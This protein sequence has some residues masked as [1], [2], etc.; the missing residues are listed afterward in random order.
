MPMHRLEKA[1]SAYD[2]QQLAEAI[3]TCPCGEARSCPRCDVLARLLYER[4]ERDKTPR[5]AA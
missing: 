2:V 4:T 5:V 3:L 1:R